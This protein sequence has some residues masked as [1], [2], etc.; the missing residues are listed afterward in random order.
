MFRKVALGMFFFLVGSSAAFA[1]APVVYFSDLVSGP[2]TGGQD[3]KGVFVTI[4]GKNFGASRG[5]S[6]VRI[7]GGAADNY[8]VWSDTKISFQLGSAA[9]TGSITVTT[10]EGTSNGVPFTVRAG[11]I[12]FVDAGSPNNP[13]TGTYDD[14]WR[15]PASFYNARQAGDTCYFRAGTYSG[16]YGYQSYHCNFTIRGTINGAANNEIAFVGYPGETAKIA[17]NSSEPTGNFEW[18]DGNSY[19]V[20]AGLTLQGAGRGCMTISGT[21]HRIV[22]NDCIGS[23]DFAYGLIFPTGSSYAKIYGNKMHGMTSGNKLSHLLYLGYGAS[24]TDF[25]WNNIYGNNIDVG[26]VISTNT[27]GGAYT[28]SNNLIHDNIINGGS[29]ARGIGF[30]AQAS[31]SSAKIYNNQFINCGGGSYAAYIWSGSVDLYNNTFYG[32]NGSAALYV[33]GQYGYNP[34]TVRVKNNLFYNPSGVSYI[35]IASESSM[36]SLTID[37]NAYYGNGSGPSRD[38]HAVNANPLVTAAASSDFHLLSTSPLIDAGTDVSA[39]VTRDFDGVL[40]PQ[41]DAFDIGVF[42]YPGTSSSLPSNT[43]PVFAAVGNKTVAENSSL[44]FSLSAS[45]ADGDPL[46]YS[47]TGLPSGAA[48]NGAVFTWVPGY[49]QAGTYT[50]TFSVSDG[51]GGTDTETSI[52]TVTNVNRSPVID[53]ISDKTV[54]EN[55]SL[56]FTV[57]AS[58]AD[59]DTVAVTAGTLPSGAAF[60][61]STRV[62]TWTPGYTQAGT[63]TVAFTA[64]DGNG[65]S[66][67]QSAKIT[68]TDAN[69]APVFT[70]VGAKTVAENTLLGFTVSATDPDGDSVTYSASGLPS[71]AVFQNATFSWTPGYDRAGTYTVTFTAG[72]GKGGTS[73]MAVPITVTNVNRTP[74][75]AVIGNQSA[76]KGSLLTFTVS[77]SDPDGDKVTYAAQGMPQ[78]AVFDTATGVFSWT[79]GQSGT[80]TVTFTASDGV[81]AVTQS[82]SIA[83]A[84]TTH[85]PVI[86]TIG[87]K[88][89]S[90]NEALT[91]TV[92]ASDA[93]GDTLSYSVSSLPNGASFKGQTFTWTPDY[94]QAGTYQPVFTVDDGNGGTASET[95]VITVKNLN[96]D[97][98][99]AVIGAKTVAENAALVFLVSAT[100][101]DGDVLTY[102]ASNL[103]QGAVFD[104]AARSFTW[105]PSAEQEGSYPV[106]FT[107]TDTNGGSASD[108]VVITVTDVDLEPPVLT[109]LIP[110]RDELQ[111]P[112]TTGIT[113]HLSDSGKGVDVQSIHM[114]VKREGDKTAVTVID[115]GKNQ[116]GAYPECISI[117]GAPADYQVTY[118]PPAARQYRF[119]YDQ[120]VTVSVTAGDLAGNALSDTY[121]FTTAMVLRG[122]NRKISGS[123]TT[124]K[125]NSSIAADASGKNVYAVWQDAGGLVRFASSSNGGS[126]FSAPVD[127]SGASGTATDP[128]IAI[129]GEQNLYV[130]WEQSGADQTRDIYLARRR[131][132]EEAFTSAVVPADSA[133]ASRADQRHPVLAAHG[134]GHVVLC[135]YNENGNDGVYYAVST[136]AGSSLWNSGTL[137]AAR[138]DDGSAEAVRAACVAVDNADRI[139]VA[140]SA[141]KSGVRSVY[142]N[143]FGADGA[144]AYASDIKVNQDAGASADK[145]S[146]SVRPEFSVSEDDANICVAWEHTHGGD[147]DIAFNR[148]FSGTAWGSDVQVNEDAT[149]E[150]PQTAPRV[151]IN[152]DGLISVIWADM[153]SGDADIYFASSLD[154]GAVFKTNMLANDDSGSAGQGA[155][156]MFLGDSADDLCMAWTDQRNGTGDIYFSRSCKFDVT[157]EVSADVAANTETVVRAESGNTALAGTEVSIPQAALDAPANISMINVELPP[158]FTNGSQPARAVEFGPSGIQFKQPVTI[159]VPYGQADLDMA[160]VN[161]PS[162]LRLYYYNL[163]TLGWEAVDSSYVDRANGC[164]R[165]EVSHFS[166]YGIGATVTESQEGAAVSSG[167]GGG[168]GGGGCFIATA[169][170]G[171]PDQADVR[172]L[173]RF[174]DRCLLTTGWGREFVKFYYRHSPA[175]ARRIEGNER[176]KFVVRCCLKPLVALA[177]ALVR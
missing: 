88:T 2:K 60:N 171:S 94:T 98:V 161:D 62:F 59:G 78:G 153:R 74:V 140:W 125:D 40:R 5:T 119:G 101:A 25:G 54:S 50:V 42:E 148:S 145:P 30:I 165:A 7:G 91:F 136:D 121:S 107:V 77:A 109:G 108:T 17:A 164:V 66:S 117:T 76:A 147:T 142:F 38:T 127:L 12:Y 144:K 51:K 28:F 157:N 1:A 41:S 83:V 149:T 118:T 80:Y 122:A 167:G 72:D 99:L 20:V 146:L 105:V 36:G 135:W 172:I 143:K 106:T 134:S 70:V 8:P 141:V 160:G 29:A 33:G 132:G 131:A 82:V 73:S 21:G 130:A 124:A 123:A 115:K 169:A 58:D 3:N 22:N 168:G 61:T 90:E 175:I 57:S 84:N 96:R 113:F 104:S 16:K 85:L 11:N 162:K 64:S 151:A 68:V 56:T 4:V 24:N 81:A 137:A 111:V 52:I 26:P 133:L 163:K 10:P 47:A 44:S 93:D 63:Y 152:A 156:C 15:S 55:S 13:G 39:V 116:L 158:S 87:P 110:A 173:R 177:K 48:L 154:G 86:D 170:Y 14:P 69:R 166:M 114:E 71:D 67:S 23:S 19:Y 46:T 49:A 6:T 95:V 18:P 128:V 31:G 129:D 75:M 45:D 32:T 176:A 159:K 150:Q 174:R 9:A 35:T 34:E 139:Y 65:G 138:V 112:R 79:P 120:A 89:V 102:Q 100:D 53:A 43:P 155:P 92:N 37:Y 97:P 103:P 27:D 126:T